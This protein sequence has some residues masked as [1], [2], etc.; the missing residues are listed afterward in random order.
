VKRAPTMEVVKPVASMKFSDSLQR[1]RTSRF[2][3]TLSEA[4][5]TGGAVRIMADNRS[6]K[7]QLEVRA[8]KLNLKLVY[9]RDGEYLYVKPIAIRPGGAL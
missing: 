6:F 8:K 3:L 7:Y 9:A 1:R 4:L 5:T 2:G